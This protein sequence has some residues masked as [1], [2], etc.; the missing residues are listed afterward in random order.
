[1]MDEL[2]SPSVQMP[3]PM[4]RPRQ[5]PA[6]TVLEPPNAWRD[7]ENESPFFEPI[8][9]RVHTVEG[10]GGVALRV[11]DAGDEY[12]PPLL[13]VHGFSQC[14]L[15]WRRQFQSALG[16][17][18]RLVALDLRGHGNSDKPH[19]AYGD[20]RVWARDIQ[21]VIRALDLERPLL[22]G[23]SY[24]GMVVADY[25]RHYGQEQVAGVHFVSA[26]VKS[27][28]E[29]AFS[30]LSP[31]LLA[32]VP[33]LF[34][35]ESGES[36]AT[37][38]T[39]VSLLHHQPVSQETRRRVLAYTELVPAYVRGAL[40]SRVEDYDDVLHRLTVPVLVT[41]GLEDR[42]VL[43]ESGRHIASMVPGALVSLYPGAGHSPFWE[44]SRR[45]NRE[46]AAFAARCW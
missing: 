20:G 28:S 41:H 11:Y 6:S 4:A 38:E 9:V 12:G 16:L 15:A 17:G 34:T 39:F 45:F 5:G 37:L 7:P 24:G 42:M 8:P 1:M 36:R 29:E 25:L 31:E 18:F 32:L 46:L 19:G 14:H 23:W 2:L 3:S 35:E 22:V 44:D 43:P 27:G 21:A 13:F 26:M 30:L 40:G 33:G 10:A